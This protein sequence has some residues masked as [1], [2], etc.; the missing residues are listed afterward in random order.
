LQQEGWKP[1][2][3]VYF[4]VITLTT[5]GLGDFVPTSD[6]AKILCAIFIYFGVACIGLLLGSYLAS[7]LDEQSYTE[8]KK[9]R[10]ENCTNCARLK[11][12]KATQR[13]APHKRGTSLVGR[14]YPSAAR[15][16]MSERDPHEMSHLGPHVLEREEK[17]AKR[18]SEDSSGPKPFDIGSPALQST[19][20]S[21]RKSDS[22]DSDKRNGSKRN[23]GAIDSHRKT[24]SMMSPEST[25]QIPG[26]PG[27]PPGSP[28]TT[29]MLGRQSHTRHM[30]FDVGAKDVFTGRKTAP[31]RPRKNTV[32]LTRQPI[33]ESIP[34]DTPYSPR[35]WT[36]GT[37][38]E[39]SET[40]EDNDDESTGSETSSSESD[41]LTD[42]AARRLKTAKYV[43]LTLK[44]AV[45][46]SILIIAVGGIGFFTIEGMSAVNS[47]YFTTVLLTTVGYGDIVPVTPAGKLFATVYVLVGGTVLLHNM[48]LI[49]MIPLE[50]RRRR[51]EQTVLTQVRSGCSYILAWAFRFPLLNSVLSFLSR[52]VW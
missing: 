24:M 9:N 16:F 7:M 33:S 25:R 30:S 46:N 3:C 26:P 27:Q 38:V 12:I 18:H 36:G 42:T 45:M 11:S 40:E 44:Q 22:D 49:S 1:L 20:G 52:A 6:G 34:E 48:S 19:K 8:A 4:A 32:D 43:F 15:G 14:S 35:S 31:P 5:A 17:R 37:R 21:G 28:F 23:L 39:E 47:F 29:E 10:V 41:V 50:L 13:K 51:I 2:D